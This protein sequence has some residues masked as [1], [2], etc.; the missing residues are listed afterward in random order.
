[1][2][3]ITLLV[4]EIA[5][6]SQIRAPDLVEQGP[7]QVEQCLNHV[8]S[9]WNAWKITYFTSTVLCT[10]LVSFSMFILILLVLSRGFECGFGWFLRMPYEAQ[11]LL[12]GRHTRVR[13]TGDTPENV[14]GHA[15][16]NIIWIFGGGHVE[17]TAWTGSVCP[18]ASC[19]A[20]VFLNESTYQQNKYFQSLDKASKFGLN[21]SFVAI[22]LKIQFSEILETKVA[23]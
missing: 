23:S 22:V 13:D 7:N 11:T 12:R 3:P 8:Y 20:S 5:G 18:F 6:Y 14:W 9:L 19:I 21:S 16:L 2:Y 10:S 15:M 4:L 1:M 17:D